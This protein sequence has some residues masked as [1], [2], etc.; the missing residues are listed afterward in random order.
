MP[1]NNQRIRKSVMG[2]NT[3][4]RC[5]CGYQKFFASTGMNN[6]RAQKKGFMIRRLHRKVC[7]LENIG[8]QVATLPTPL[9][10]DLGGTQILDY[11]N[12]VIDR[13]QQ[14]RDQATQ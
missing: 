6:D 11:M 7:P 12:I 9:A 8:L 13:E 1:K 5:P 10:S 14:E 4:Y 2:D 3:M